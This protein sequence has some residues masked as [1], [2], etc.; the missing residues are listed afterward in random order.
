MKDFSKIKNG[1]GCFVLP[2]VI[3][4]MFAGA[5]QAQN[6]LLYDHQAANN[7]SRAALDS[8]GLPYTT[9]TIGDFDTQL[10]SQGW[11]LVIIDAP[12]EIPVDANASSFPSYGSLQWDA[13]EA[14]L[15][16]GGKA[17]MSFWE[18]SSSPSSVYSGLSLPET[19]GVNQNFSVN[20][21]E[22]DG[23]QDVH[24]WDASHPIF[25]GIT[26]PLT[27]AADFNPS[28]A[29]TT[30]GTFLNVQSG[31]GVSAVAGFVADSNQIFQ[32]AIIVQEGAFGPQTIYN[33]FLFDEMISDAGRALIANEI[34]YVLGAAIPEPSSG[35]LLGLGLVLVCACARRWRNIH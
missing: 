17:I 4:L 27:A 22:T 5:V 2:A 8:L 24:F 16:T 13:M 12:D 30:L 20:Y 3:A 19:F 25:N 14:Y 23:H 26:G 21:T 1:F 29:I 31:V 15:A 34:S 11:D 28:P 7:N 9:S 35:A 33:G 32:S 10:G 6:I 18:A